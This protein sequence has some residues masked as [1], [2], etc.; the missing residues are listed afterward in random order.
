MG[1][2]SLV[3]PRRL[4]VMVFSL[5]AAGLGGCNP[6]SVVPI[7]F[8]EVRSYLSAEEIAISHP[9]E[10]VVI[11]AMLS[12]KDSGFNIA[13][14]EKSAQSGKL[15]ANWGNMQA[16]ISIAY[17]TPQM[18]RI[19][20]KVLNVN[21]MRQRSSEVLLLE[22]IDKHLQQKTIATWQEQISGMAPVWEQPD[23]NTA[24]VAY[25]AAGAILQ[26][27]SVVDGWVSLALMDNRVGYIPTD[28]LHKKTAS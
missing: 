16:A 7:T 4:S 19:T 10:P 28:F 6:M 1:C 18:T 14:A 9:L 27:E 15:Q 2:I 20:C 21:L 23:R 22:L 12:L 8:S 17:V 25:L 5:L 26:V 24:P 13:M 3:A 11:A